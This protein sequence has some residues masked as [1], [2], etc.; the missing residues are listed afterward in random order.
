MPWDVLNSFC[1]ANENGNDNFTLKLEPFLTHE[2]GVGGTLCDI[3]L[4][5]YSTE[6]ILH[7]SGSSRK[8]R[9]RRSELPQRY[10]GGNTPPRRRTMM[11]TPSRVQMSNF[12]MADLDD[13]PLHLDTDWGQLARLNEENR[14]RV[15]TLISKC[16][17]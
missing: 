3:Y 9:R 4:V 8:D 12:D 16:I 10:L 13:E 11:G 15:C 14:I 17:I 5:K 2:R 7:S 1:R 6:N